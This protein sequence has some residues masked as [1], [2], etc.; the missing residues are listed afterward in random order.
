MDKDLDKEDIGTRHRAA[1][2]ITEESDA[3]AVIVSEETG[4]ISLAVRGKLTRY[5]S[6]LEL[7][8]MLLVM[9]RPSFRTRM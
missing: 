9:I 8:G 4:I 6:P 1:C 3:V 7:R 2:G 5:L